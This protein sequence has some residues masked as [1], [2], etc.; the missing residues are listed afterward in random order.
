MKSY[1][2]YKSSVIK[3]IKQ[4]PSHWK[5]TKLKFI[6]NLYSGLTGKSGNDFYN[7][8]NPLSRP[9]INFKNIANNVK[10]NPKQFDLV[11]IKANEQQNKVKKGDLFF[12]MSSENFDDIA[13]TAVLTD[14]LEDTYLNSFCRGFRIQD[15]NFN[16]EFLNY[17]LLS[18][19]YREILSNEAKG[20]TRINIQVGKINNFSIYAPFNKEEQIQI[21]AFLDYKTNL[22]DAI[23][24]K[25]KQLIALLKEK[26]QAVINEAV[27]KGLNPNAKMK[28]SGVEW[29]GDIPEHWNVKKLKFAVDFLSEK[30]S[31]IKRG[32][33]LEDITSWSGKGNLRDTS[34][35]EGDLI[36]F[37]KGDVL[38]NKLRPYLAKVY[39]ANESGGAVGELM[40]LRPKTN[41]ITQIFL[42]NR[43]ISKAF[44][45]VVDGST[46]GAKMPRASVSFILDLKFG[47]PPIEEQFEINNHIKNQT[48]LYNNIISKSEASIKNL[49]TYRQSLISEAVTGK[50]DVRDWQ[51]P[52]K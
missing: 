41:V 13:K 44:I 33:A 39:M 34:N 14:E 24:E 26:R 9:Y 25:K 43:L 37:E 30:A 32:I 7:E 19:H 1:E 3:G 52:K 5:P 49:Q 4:I 23:I 8:D 22:I 51:P 17:L 21:A 42:F 50:I 18:G 47:I 46:Y 29:L 45:D 48:E 6:G 40:V 10:I 28:N 11:E 12:L 16:P 36:L 15:E 35:F 2:N 31:D 27:T 20:F 38:F